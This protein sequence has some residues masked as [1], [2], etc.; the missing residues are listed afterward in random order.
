LAEDPIVTLLD[1]SFEALPFQPE[2]S[3]EYV[4]TK[5][6]SEKVIPYN[7]VLPVGPILED[8]TWLATN[9]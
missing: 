3:T 1:I 8:V 7:L 2:L 4:Y 9:M 5:Y 6:H